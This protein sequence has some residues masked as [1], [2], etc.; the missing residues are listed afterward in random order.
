[1][2]LILLLITVAAIPA[3]SQVVRAFIAILSRVIAVA[4]VVTLAFVFLLI[5][6]SHLNFR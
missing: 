6:S 4:I 3:A 5:I 2:D 1:M